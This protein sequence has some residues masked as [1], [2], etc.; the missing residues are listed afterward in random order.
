MGTNT[1]TKTKPFDKVLYDQT[2]GKAKRK[3]KKYL[4]SKDHI[5]Q[6]SKEYYKCD[7]KSI[8]GRGIITFSEVE[9]KLSWEGEW[10]TSWRDVRIPYRKKKLLD[11]IESDLT[12][13]I[14]RKDCK[15]MWIIPDYIIKEKGSVVEVP[16][17]Y[18][19]EGEQFY[20][21][22]VESIKK[23]KLTV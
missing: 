23:V 22:P 8:S 21:I 10:P 18:V 12:F 7:V 14:F 4:H 16:N 15:E 2:D 19:R 13:Y 20:S 1:L 9:I 3:I 17:R 5:V 6:D 11:E